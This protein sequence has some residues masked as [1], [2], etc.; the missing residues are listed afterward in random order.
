MKL[1]HR[2]L[3]E[4]KPLIILHG[5]FGYSDNWQTIGKK[6]AEY[7][8][9]ILVDQ[10]NHGHSSWSDEMNY[11]LMADDL[12]ELLDELGL[13]EILLLGHSMGGKAAI[14]FAE[15]YPDKLEKLVVVDIGIKE[16][17]SHH[18]LILEGLNAIDVSKLESRSE[19]EEQLSKY[20]DSIGTKQFLLKNLYWI[21]KGKLAWRMNIPVL[22]KNMPDI[23]AALSDKE[24]FTPVLFVRGAQSS[25]IKDEDV[26]S[27]EKK[28]VDFKLAT[29]EDAGH[30]I[31][32]EAPDA[33]LETVLG[34][35][36]R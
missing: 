22:E 24:I 2:I 27:L 34:F 6:L 31:H 30:W 12:S 8:Q 15:K 14:R 5:L 4:G 23:L 32:A 29:I 3:G 17:P 11:D 1:H 36:I 18:D 13:A 7:F 10:R 26:P 19:A 9:V 20:V 25:Y 16:Y 28:F 33:F 21:E 35:L